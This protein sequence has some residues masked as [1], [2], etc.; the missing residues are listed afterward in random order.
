[1][2]RQHTAMVRH[3]RS[4]QVAMPS[5]FMSP[6]ALLVL[7]AGAAHLAT[8][9]NVTDCPGYSA[10]NVKSTDGGLTADL[11]LAGDACDA[12]GKDLYDLKFMM[13]YQTGT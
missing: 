4:S 10:S 6:R 3:F 9:Q 13:E 2:V 1:M 5:P 12:Y 11:T 7:W 8:A